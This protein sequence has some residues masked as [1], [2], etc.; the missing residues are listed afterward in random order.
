MSERRFLAT[1]FMGER[2]REENGEGE[3]KNVDGKIK[4]KTEKRVKKVKTKINREV[5]E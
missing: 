3:R 1:P 4:R 2:E 5:G